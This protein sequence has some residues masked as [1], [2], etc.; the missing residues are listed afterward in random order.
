MNGKS[1][2]TALKLSINAEDNRIKVTDKRKLYALFTVKVNDIL[3]AIHR[4]AL[5]GEKTDSQI[6]SERNNLVEA[7]RSTLQ[8]AN[9]IYLI[10]PRDVIDAVDEMYSYLTECYEKA[11]DGALKISLPDKEVNDLAGKIHVRMRRDL[12]PDWIPRQ[13]ID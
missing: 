11:Y 10:A 7:H 1:Q 12:D 2:L 13:S 3:L 9:E 6:E 4:C 8:T 5:P